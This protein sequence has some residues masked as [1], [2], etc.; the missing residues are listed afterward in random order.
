MT[1]PF[2]LGMFG[3]GVSVA[4]TAVLIAR[5]SQPGIPHETYGLWALGSLAL[6]VANVL[7]GSMGWVIFQGSCAVIYAWLWWRGRRNGRMKKAAK[8]LGAKS[9]AR[10]EALVEQLTPSPIP[11]PGGTS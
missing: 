4:G 8:E 2:L 11:T 1:L 10:V 6:F 9:R 7:D 3:T 5:W